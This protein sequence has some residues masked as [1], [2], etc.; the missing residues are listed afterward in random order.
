[1]FLFVKKLTTQMKKCE[2]RIARFIGGRERKLAGEMGLFSS[3]RLV[4]GKRYSSYSVLDYSILHSWDH[5]IAQYEN[6][7]PN[8][9]QGFHG[10]WSMLVD[11]HL[12]LFVC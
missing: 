9:E 3:T 6:P 1:M 12:T 4:K 5:E 7:V 10:S 11:F 2:S 8:Q